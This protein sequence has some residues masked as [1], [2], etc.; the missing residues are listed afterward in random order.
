[1]AKISTTLNQTLKALAASRSVVTLGKGV[2]YCENY[3][4]EGMMARIVGFRIEDG[5]CILLKFDFTEFDNFNRSF[6]SSNY[7]DQQGHA[8]LTA[9]LA[10]YYKPIDEYFFGED[11]LNIVKPVEDARINLL[12][13]WTEETE[14]KITYVAWLENQVLILAV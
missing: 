9:R 1:M 11:V 10:G 14:G 8:T 13:R 4:E 7:Y 12:K 5:D 2:E 6:E 3:A